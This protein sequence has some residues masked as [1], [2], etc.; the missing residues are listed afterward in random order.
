MTITP[1]SNH[2]PVSMASDPAPTRQ[3]AAA[4]KPQQ[5]AEDSVHLSSQAKL[6]AGDVDHDGDSH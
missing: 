2:A 4:S 3:S 5:P 1:V 6:A